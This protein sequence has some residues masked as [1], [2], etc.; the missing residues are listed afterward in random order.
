MYFYFHEAIGEDGLS[1]HNLQNTKVTSLLS[2]NFLFANSSGLQHSCHFAL[3]VGFQ[4]SAGNNFRSLWL[5][6]LCNA[7]TVKKGHVCEIFNPP[8]IATCKFKFLFGF[9]LF[10]FGILELNRPMQESNHSFFYGRCSLGQIAMLRTETLT[11]FECKSV[12][13]SGHQAW[14]HWVF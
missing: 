14:D 7:R 10:V 9:F 4:H 6:V 11:S 12:L 1:R 2:A 8:D 13:K 5:Q 3:T